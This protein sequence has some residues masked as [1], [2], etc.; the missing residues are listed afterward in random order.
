MLDVYGWRRF[1]TTREADFVKARAILGAPWRLERYEYSDQGFA[2][3]RL[4]NRLV[5]V[6]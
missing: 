5:W 2:F 1:S 3:P 6:S 4:F